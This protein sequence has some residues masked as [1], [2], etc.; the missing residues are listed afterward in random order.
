MEERNMAKLFSSI[1]TRA[2]I[3]PVAVVALLAGHDR[4]CARVE[5]DPQKEYVITPGVGPW[6]ICVA[7]FMGEASQQFAHNLVLELRTKYDLPAYVYNRGAEERRAQQAE[8]E[9]R[10]QK[11][12]EQLE[13]MGAHADIALPVRTVHIEEQYAVLIG[14]Y[15]DMDTAHSELERI[16]KM[17]A[18][19]SVPLDHL[20]SIFRSSKQQEG[21]PVNPTVTC[22]AC[23]NSFVVRNP[24]VPFEH[25]RDTSSLKNLNADEEYSLLKCPKRWT[26]MVKNFQGVA[27]V[28]AGSFWEKVGLGKQNDLM[29]ASA[30]QAHEVAKA[31]KANGFEAYVLHTK[32]GSIVTVGGYDTDKDPHLLQNQK[33]LANLRLGIIQLYAQ[34]I[35]MEVPR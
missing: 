9:N 27:I 6:A 32:Y 4:A 17:S 23:L 14:G 18:P 2:W 11:Q 12:R 21:A 31:L 30:N 3:L 29:T 19:Q 15:P 10:R 5:A 34:P 22:P 28:Q 33:C 35:P 25:V 26:L 24:T 13:R 8:L 7:S 20:L 1:P 16:K